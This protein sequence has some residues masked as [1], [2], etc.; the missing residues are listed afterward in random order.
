[1]LRAVSLRLMQVAFA[2]LPPWFRQAAG[3]D[4]LVTHAERFRECA[5]SGALVRMTVRELASLLALAIRLRFLPSPVSA[6]PRLP[7]FETL[8]QDIAFAMR[9]FARR[10]TFSL[11]VVLTFG[12]GIGA[13]T[14]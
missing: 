11:L 6:S 2:L 3:R 4:L 7:M 12:L 8:Q 14:A 10:W 9:G 1:M 13:T 5:K